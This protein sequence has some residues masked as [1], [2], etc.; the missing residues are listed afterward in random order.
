[1]TWSSSYKTLRE[2]PEE[3]RQSFLSI[4]E[5][6]RLSTIPCDHLRR[7][8]A[9]GEIEVFTT[10]IKMHR[11]LIRV[12]RL[13]AYI[14]VHSVHLGVEPIPARP[15]MRRVL[16]LPTDPVAARKH[17]RRVSNEAF[18]KARSEMKSRQAASVRS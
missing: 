5:A 6:S 8:V 17:I 15:R 14:A 12:D 18:E 4:P 3:H 16:G 1:M 13:R 7:S 9:N 11:A 2:I 10:G